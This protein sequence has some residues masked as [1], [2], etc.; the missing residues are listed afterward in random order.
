M[1]SS[2]LC[3][4]VIRLRSIILILFNLW[5]NFFV[6]RLTITSRIIK[7]LG[8]YVQLFLGI[9]TGN[10]VSLVNVMDDD[11]KIGT[12][13]DQL[14]RIKNQLE[15]D[16]YDVFHCYLSKIMYESP[17][18]IID[19]CL[20][21]GFK[22]T[23]IEIFQYS[24]I[25]D[26]TKYTYSTQAAVIYHEESNRIIVAFRGTEPMDLFQW[27]TDA[28]TKFTTIANR[29]H[30][31]NAQI[32]VHEGFCAALG[33]I[34]EFDPLKSIDFNRS[35]NGAPMFIQILNSI[36]NYQRNN[37]SCQITITGHSLGAGLASLFSYV[38]LQ[39]NY[40]S[41]ISG[42][43]TYGQPLVGNRHFAMFLNKKLGNRFHRWVN[44]N[45]IV[46]RIPVIE[47]PSIA[48]YY[49][50]T[51]YSDALEAAGNEN[52][53]VGKY[54]FHAGLLCRIDYQGN[55]V[56]QNFDDQEPKSALQDRLHLFD[57]KYSIRNAIYSL[58]NITLL[59]AISWLIVPT[60]INDHFP[61]DYAR[62]IKK[63]VTSK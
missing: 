49:A 33:L 63:I 34:T 39:Y 48:W 40:E 30:D 31:D 45:D 19:Q 2:F 32:R 27:L 29:F 14:F 1:F 35:M 38:L 5:L 23:S 51:P 8:Q 26:V 59:R 24:Q 58:F 62:N 4:I 7:F 56:K 46:P 61:G 53:I 20:N 12:T 3:S 42:V 50:R 44:H 21:W 52:R 41:L 37:K 13:V 57:N 10:H 22:K 25:E 11:F 36:Q 18:A 47:L 54:Y 9:L 60:E 6:K 17:S 16:L 43:Y 28:S 55:L 15:P